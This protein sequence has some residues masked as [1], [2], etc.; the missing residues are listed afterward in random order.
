MGLSSPNAPTLDLPARFM[1]LSVISLV[2]MAVTAP[3]TL[4]LLQRSFADFDLLA[5]VHL[6][7]LGF[8]GAMI[9]GASY[10][11]VP[12]ALQ[13]PLASARLGRLSFWLYLPG[14]V[15]FLLGL[16][17]TW[18]YVL[19]TGATLLVIAF[20]LYI[21]VVITTWRRTPRRDVV[22]W[23]ILL[24]LAGVT[25]GMSLGFLL[26]HNKTD[27]M[28]GGHV[29]SVLAAHVILM[30]GGWVLI[31]FMGVAYRLIGMF[32]LSEQQF[33]P[34]LAWAALTLAEAGIWLLAIR[35][36]FELPSVIGQIAA[37]L[38]LAGLLCFAAQLIH[39]YRRRMRRGFDIH[40]PFAATAALLA[41]ASVVLLVIG[42]VTHQSPV[43]PIWIAAGWLALLG[44]AETAI[45]G[46][47]YKISTFLV[48]LKR[49]APVAG[50][51]PVPKLE[52]LYNK[53]LAV[54]GWAL[55]TAAMVAGTIA[56]LANWDVLA[57]IGLLLLAGVL[58]FLVNVVAI[59]RH[60]LVS[61]RS[62][63]IGHLITRNGA[64]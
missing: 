58:C 23:H 17:Q 52:Q 19:V 50:R 34:R 25:A 24:G 64:P 33:R 54:A 43:A 11:L 28:L 60:W 10:Q 38:L 49:Y 7:T 56:I 16:L 18:L 14:L 48:W 39:L 36:L 55:W 63:L 6:N 13:T 12:V 3:W 2:I 30:F 37:A 26:A 29:L 41:L 61:G 35:F 40:I 57:P 4:P 45:Q 8:V 22:A 47:F 32:T 9:I 46:F 5:F 31:T 1:A 20:I 27:G 53:R 44:G 51:E 21:G 59:A 15:I 42:L 62:R